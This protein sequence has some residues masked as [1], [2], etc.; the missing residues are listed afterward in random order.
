LA[1]GSG[2]LSLPDR[3]YLFE[4]RAKSVNCASNTWRTLTKIVQLLGAGQESRYRP[5]L[6]NGGIEKP[7][8]PND[9]LL[10]YRVAIRIRPISK[11]TV[12][13]TVFR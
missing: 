4:G 13:E 3:D 2:R 8:W 6:V 10:V 9:R 1:G 11:L 12:H 5:P 7:S